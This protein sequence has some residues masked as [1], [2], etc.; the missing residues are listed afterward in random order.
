[1]FDS[2][3]HLQDTRIENPREA[4]ARAREAGVHTTLL[5]GVDAD[6]W[7]RQ[8]PLL[9][10]EG[11][12]GS[13][14][15]HPWVVAARDVTKDLSAL[16]HALEAL[17]PKQ[18]ALGE[19]GLD[20]LDE[21]R[22]S[23]EAQK[24]AFCT[25]LELAQTFNLPVILHVLRAHEEALA[26]LKSIGVPRRGGVVHSYSGG[27]EVLDR[28]LRLGLHVSFSGAVTWPAAQ[29]GQNRVM[30]A[31]EICPIDRLLI[32]TDAPDQTPLPY[33]PGPCRIEHLGAIARAIAEKRGMT[34]A[35]VAQHAEQNARALFFRT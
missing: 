6:D 23:L 31:A 35:A 9:E 28:Y 34:P 8:I 19:I 15:I 26:V 17:H 3:S 5:A 25:Q 14:G 2:H 12:Y 13:V 27:P 7:Q 1:M 29:G 18:V 32:E 4:W 30:R 33:R 22:A 11:V 10:L 21:R 16:E 20:K 24:R